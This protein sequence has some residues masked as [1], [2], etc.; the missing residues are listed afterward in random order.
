MNKL[1]TLLLVLCM[2]SLASATTISLTDEH[3]TITASPG[4]DVTLT[5]SSNADGVTNPGLVYIDLIISVTG[6]DVISDALNLATASSYGWDPTLSWSVS[7]S[8]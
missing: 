7:G 4:S 3:T 5:I 8:W 2:A 1:F 6:G